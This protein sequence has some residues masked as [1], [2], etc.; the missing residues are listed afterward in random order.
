MRLF[1]PPSQKARLLPRAVGLDEHRGPGGRRCLPGRLGGQSIRTQGGSFP[2]LKNLTQLAL[3][4]L[5]PAWA[6]SALLPFQFLPFGVSI[7]PL[8]LD[9]ILEAREFSSF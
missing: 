4:G 5:R 3:L 7:P 2:M 8:S 6:M 9:C 1:P